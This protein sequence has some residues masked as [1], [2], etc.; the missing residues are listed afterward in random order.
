MRTVQDIIFGVSGQT[1][2]FDP[3]EGRPSSVTSVEVFH[4]DSDDDNPELTG[5]GLV[6]SNPS[7]TTDAAAGHGQSDPR[8]IP[9]TATTGFEVGQSY[10]IGSSAGPREWF[11]VVE[12]N[13]SVSVTARHPLHNAYSSGATV[14]TTRITADVDDT[15]VADDTNLDETSGPNPSYRV[16]WQ[17][18]VDSVT[19]VADTYFTLVRY[20]GAHGIRPQDVESLAHGWLD[21]LPTDHRQDQGRR[22]I[23]EAYRAVKID[24]HAIWTDDA[25]VAN[26]EILDELTRYKA[27]EQTELARIMAGG[28]SR[29]AYD[30]VRLAYQSRF[31]SLAKVT[32]KLPVRHKDGGATHRV[33]V[34]LTRR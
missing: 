4:Y 27:L 24:L 29:E 33:G 19:H 8:L 12:I 18:V 15:W 5:T 20:K 25:M 16:R 21:R 34:G 10:L 2:T 32:N 9:V 7:T 31:D 1:L 11:E 13:S 17:Y 3:P 23:D 26:S 28:G 22:L 6:Q 14:A 30:V